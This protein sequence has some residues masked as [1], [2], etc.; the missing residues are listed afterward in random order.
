MGGADEGLW[1][2]WRM[3]ARRWRGGVAHQLPARSSINLRI[4]RNQAWFIANSILSIVN[5]SDL[6]QKA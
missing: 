3:G 4:E 2:G 6:F 5:A 1:E